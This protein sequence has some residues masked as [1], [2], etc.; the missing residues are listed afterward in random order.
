MTEL[1]KKFGFTEEQLE[2]FADNF[3]R[4]EIA[5]VPKDALAVLGDYYVQ[6]VEKAVQ[7]T[8][9]GMSHEDDIVSVS[10]ALC[11]IYEDGLMANELYRPIGDIL[12]DKLIEKAEQGYYSHANRS[13][14]GYWRS[15]KDNKDA[16]KGLKTILEK[17][18]N[19]AFGQKY[20]SY[21]NGASPEDERVV[22]QSYIENPNMYF[23]TTSMV[24]IDGTLIKNGKAN[25]NLIDSIMAYTDGYIAIYTGGDPVSQKKVLVKSIAEKI[26]E[27]NPL[28]KGEFSVDTIVN[29]YSQDNEQ[30][31]ALREKLSRT[32]RDKIWGLFFNQEPGN[33][34]DAHMIDDM[35]NR[36]K[37][38]LE[39]LNRLTATGGDQIKIYPKQA[40]A[41]ENICLA[42][43]V[44]DDTQP[45]AQGMKS[46]YSAC[47]TPGESPFWVKEI[48]GVE[49]GI[50][51][52]REITAEQ[53]F[54]MYQQKCK[55]NM[56]AGAKQVDTLNATE[57]KATAFSDS[58][59]TG[60]KKTTR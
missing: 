19:Y 47:L 56:I 9:K 51:K 16:Q 12:L 45:A 48:R 29:M 41:Q 28:I 38:I 52:E 14:D 31:I 37:R 54:A 34:V 1:N 5:Q 42:D 20:L 22:I 10:H 3:R 59:K 44:I 40:F 11:H 49:R 6:L 13:I 50:S 7:A 33:K 17:H 39:F 18:P 53:A 25:D 27:K 55:E 21:M 2:Q 4:G 30:N 35:A 24:D 26:L 60:V 46:L 58:C 36:A 8:E 23:V 57:K 32:L 15:V 43:T